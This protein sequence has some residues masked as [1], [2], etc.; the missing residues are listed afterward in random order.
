MWSKFYADAKRG[1]SVFISCYT[2]NTS[3]PSAF[4][5]AVSYLPGWKSSQ[6]LL[7]SNS[8]TAH[9]IFTCMWMPANGKGWK[10][11][12]G[13]ENDLLPL[14]CCKFGNNFLSNNVLA[15]DS[16]IIR[17]FCS[18]IWLIELNFIQWN[19][20]TDEFGS[21]AFIWQ[22]TLFY[23]SSFKLMVQV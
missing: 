5:Q 2:V 3:N 19:F 6:Q 20:T 1:S 4:Q 23:V 10:H 7:V 14:T 16:V 21:C 13:D 11:C 12:M 15:F 8:W 22:N 18:T 17:V 9:Y